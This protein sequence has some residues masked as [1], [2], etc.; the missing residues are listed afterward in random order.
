MKTNVFVERI[1]AFQCLVR[2]L[3]LRRVLDNQFHALVPA[4]VSNDLGVNP[5]NRLEFAR[6]VEFVMRPR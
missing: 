2:E 6:P 5:R 3:L 4:E 1:G